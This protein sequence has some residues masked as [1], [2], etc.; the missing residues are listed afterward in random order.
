MAMHFY[1]SPMSSAMRVHWALEELG[2]PYEKHKLDLAAGDQK[3]PDFLAIN[4]NGKV[5][6]LVDGDAKI[7]ESLA[8]FVWL[9]EKYGTEKGMW[10]RAG[11]PEHGAALSW[12]MWGTAEAATTMFQYLLHGSEARM[13]LPKEHRS[14]HLA[15]THKDRFEQLM[16]VLDGHLQGRDY[17]LGSTFSLVDVANASMVGFA[18]MMGGLSL[19]EHKNVAAWLARCQQRPSMARVM[20]N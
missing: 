18:T 8:I 13:A 7:F 4:P 19:A 10:P 20:G 16:K 6:A 14:A 5:P 9:G 2:V 11:T 12:L 3:K 15:K 1:Y 17:T